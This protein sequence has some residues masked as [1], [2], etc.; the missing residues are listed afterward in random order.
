[1]KNKCGR[2][3]SHLSTSENNLFQ[4]LDLWGTFYLINMAPRI[5]ILWFYVSGGAYVLLLSLL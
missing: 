4:Q 5:I 1:M 3:E 2:E